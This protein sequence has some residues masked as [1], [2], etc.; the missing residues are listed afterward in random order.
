[1]DRFFVC[2]DA[3]EDSYN[4][5]YATVA[6]HLQAL[7][8]PFSFVVIVQNCC[9]ETW[10][11]GDRSIL[12]PRPSTD[13]LRDLLTH[14]DVSQDDPEAMPAKAGYDTRALFHQDYLKAIVRDRN[15]GRTHDRIRYTK[16]RVGYFGKPSHF[17][18]LVDRRNETGHLESFGH[19]V[20]ALRELG[21]AV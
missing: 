17:C 6:G 13:E 5:R 19:L 15:E 3:E 18:A 20:A 2:L 9:I 14:Y 11:L 10:F 12:R 21:A 16:R 8:P 4:E 7:D 1:M